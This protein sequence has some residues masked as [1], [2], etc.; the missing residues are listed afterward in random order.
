MNVSTLTVNF[1]GESGGGRRGTGKGGME[2][3][4]VREAGQA[5]ARGGEPSG[6]PAGHIIWDRPGYLVRRLH[7]IHVAMFLDKVARGKVTPIQYGL[8]SILVTR[9]NIDQLTIGE[10][11]GLDRANVAD[12]LKRLE[13][14]KL[15]SRVID[16]NNRRRKLC[17]ATP[18]GAELVRQYHIDMK[19]SQQALLA[20]L[21]PAE[22]DTFMDLLTRLV[23]GNNASGR[24]A[25]RGAVRPLPKKSTRRSPAR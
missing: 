12:I 3:S 21:S 10:E 19:A 5:A 20:P 18:K 23:E 17:L 22:R 16:P 11:L 24:A 6:A 4:E 7:Q 13:A 1:N 25:L 9:P 2:R 15:V 8:L 14:R